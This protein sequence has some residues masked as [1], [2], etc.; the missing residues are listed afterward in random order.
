MTF[1]CARGR[2]NGKEGDGAYVDESCGLKVAAVESASTDGNDAAKDNKAGDDRD[3]SGSALAA[4]CVLEPYLS[5]AGSEGVDDDD[6]GRLR[7]T[8]VCVCILWFVQ[9]LVI[10]T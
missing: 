7:F 1:A 2:G 8:C 3:I 9:V 10:C 5:A 6:V 4:L